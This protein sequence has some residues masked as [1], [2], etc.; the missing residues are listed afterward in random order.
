MKRVKFVS[1][2]NAKMA[3]VACAVAGFTLTGC[4]KE[5]FTVDV[6]PINVDV[7][8]FEIPTAEEGLV[9]L[10]LSA[11]ANTG[12]SLV[13][14]DFVATLPDETT[15][16]LEAYN[17][18]ATKYKGKTVSIMASSTGFYSNVVDVVIPN[19]P[20]GQIMTL[21]VNIVLEKV[22]LEEGVVP[23]TI[24]DS[25]PV[26]ETTSSEEQ[27][28]GNLSEGTK[29]VE[30]SVPDG[31]PYMT[32]DQKTEL[33][34]A[35]A[36]LTED[37]AIALTRAEVSDLETAK[38]N[39]R[40]QIDAYRS[41][42]SMNGRMSITLEVSEGGANNVKATVETTEETYKITLATIVNNKRYEVSGECTVPVKNVVTVEAEGVDVSHS[43]DHGNNPNAGGGIIE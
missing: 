43:H 2:F 35:V 29:V 41:T 1:G 28:L 15:E 25:T 33:Y 11:T 40:A 16:T 17:W 3:L 13:D 30:I 10:T 32:A 19:V 27:N 14:V 38:A 23:P 37:D 26:E 21:P 22:D 7:P 18:N 8:P 24:D 9:Y 39:L 20:A 6:P 5:E 42:Q 36:T 12:E 4:E 34:N 31:T